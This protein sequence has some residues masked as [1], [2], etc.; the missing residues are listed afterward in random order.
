MQTARRH[1]HVVGHRAVRAVTK[2]RTFGTQVV[3]ARPAVKALAANDGR[4]FRDDAVPLTKSLYAAPGSG[5]GA[6][7]LMAEHDRHAHRPALRVVVL[8]DIAPA[9]ADRAALQ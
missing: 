3:F 5:D 7:K 2:T 6:A 1:A 8:M 9:D 4:G